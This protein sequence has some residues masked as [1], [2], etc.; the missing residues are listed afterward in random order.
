MASLSQPAAPGRRPAGGPAGWEPLVRD[1]SSEASLLRAADGPF[2]AA[3]LAGFWDALHPE[4]FPSTGAWE[5]GHHQ[6]V[7]LLRRTAWWVAGPCICEYVYEDT[8]APTVQDPAMASVIVRITA[9][10]TEACGVEANPPNSCN[11]NFYPPGGG[12]GYHADDEPIF[13]GP[14]DE[15]LIISLSLV[16]AGDAAVGDGTRRFELRKSG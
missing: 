6:G 13:G 12:V 9:R 2:Q 5:A 16:A 14:A 11:L 8:R 1:G 4:R 3:E 10:V 7:E 15:K